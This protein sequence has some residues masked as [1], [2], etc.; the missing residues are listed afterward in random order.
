MSG[1]NTD[2]KSELHNLNVFTYDLSEG[3]N[4]VNMSNMGP[5]GNAK[6]TPW[7]RSSVG[8]SSANLV[9]QANPLQQ[10][11]INQ[12][13]LGNMNATGMVQFQQQH[14][15]VFQNAMGMQQQNLGIGIQPIPNANVAM[16][17]AGLGTQI[18]ASNQLFQQVLCKFTSKHFH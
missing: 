12:G 1:V 6:N 18:A 3:H 14:Q 11:L 9:N 5:F 10:Q 7:G 2:V 15:Q 4:C 17:A 8:N 16:G 13:A